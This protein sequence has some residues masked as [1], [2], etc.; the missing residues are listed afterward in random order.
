MRRQ[1]LQEQAV[2]QCTQAT[3]ATCTSGA[4]LQTGPQKRRGSG[5]GPDLAAQG[6]ACTTSPG[7]SCHSEL[8]SDPDGADSDCAE[9][10]SIAADRTVQCRIENSIIAFMSDAPESIHLAHAGEQVAHSSVSSSFWQ[11]MP[12][13][14]PPTRFD[15]NQ[16]CFLRNSSRRGRGN[17]REEATEKMAAVVVEQTEGGTSGMVDSATC[18]HDGQRHGT[19]HADREYDR[20]AHHRDLPGDSVGVARHAVSDPTAPLRRAVAIVTVPRPRAG[21]L[22]NASTP[23]RAPAAGRLWAF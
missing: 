15:A 1:L 19:S 22:G 2:T 11:Q 13:L 10:E 3:Q 5:R 21:V 20:T 12:T 23:R 17:R 18:V 8:D 9:E 6:S 4:Q 7:P 16:L 14:P